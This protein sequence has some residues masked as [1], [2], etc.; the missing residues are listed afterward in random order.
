MNTG[1]ICPKCG[2]S[3]SPWVSECPCY[4]DRTVITN[5]TVAWGNTKAGRC[6][7]VCGNKTEFG[8]CRTT[9]CIK[10]EYRIYEDCGGVTY[11]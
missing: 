10:P 3:L 2:R 8:Y 4:W 11:V 1:W 9:V 7:K 5:S 6:D